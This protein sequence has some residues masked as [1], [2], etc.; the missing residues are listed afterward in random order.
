MNALEKI[1]SKNEDNKF[2]CVG[3]DTDINK[4]PS[5]IKN[6]KDAIHFFNKK[7]IEATKGSVAAYKI[8]FA[9]YEVFGPYGLELIEKTLHEI[10]SEILVIADSKR[11]DISN[12]SE[13]YA[14][15]VFEYFNFDAV[16][17][18]PFM[19]FDSIEPFLRYENKLT[20]LLGLTSNQGA[21]DFQKL[22]IK[23]GEKL[24]QYIIKK[25]IEWNYKFK[26]CGLVFGAT[27]L[28]E[29][30]ENI[31]AF[32]TL[33]ILLPGVGSQGGSFDDVVK[34][35]KSFHRKNF[36]I[37][38]SRSIIYKDQSLNFDAAARLE[39]IKLNNIA[40]QIFSD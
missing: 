8:N 36:L 27:N 23:S 2:I 19:G 40:N 24:F 14:K 31:K 9:F 35:F 37:N 15:S 33:P 22:E 21:N 17:V 18:N 7:I 26:N 32:D 3:L 4:I 11:G 38:L 13:M 30:K 1:I 34:L 12:T 29:L 6:E 16:T 5:V 10:P 39:I 20:F 25:S 28:E